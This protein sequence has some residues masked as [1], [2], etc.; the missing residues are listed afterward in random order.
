MKDTQQDQNLYREWIR[1]K[2]GTTPSPEFSERIF[3]EIQPPSKTI[4]IFNFARAAI[5]LGAAILGIGR[6]AILIAITLF[7]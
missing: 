1:E 2:Q 5:L 4:S 6:Y 3:N 7:N